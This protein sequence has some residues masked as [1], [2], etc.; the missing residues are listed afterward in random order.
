MIG[1][2]TLFALLAVLAPVDRGREIYERGDAAIEAEV[3]GAIVASS[4]VTCASC[5]GGDGRGRAEGGES[6]SDLRPEMLRR[7]Y[8]VTA[9]SGRRHG[10][11]DDRALVRAIVMG[12]DPA[13]NRLS[14]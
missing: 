6:P 14:V 2:E 4:L 1:A 12:L 13:G 9:P 8:D 11:Y 3:S 7:S 10:P 5:H